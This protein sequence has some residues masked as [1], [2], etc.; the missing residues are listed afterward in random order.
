MTGTPNSKDQF[1]AINML[2]LKSSVSEVAPLVIRIIIELALDE[3]HCVASCRFAPDWN[4]RKRQ[5]DLGDQFCDNISLANLWHYRNEFGFS[6][7]QKRQQASYLPHCRCVHRS[8]KT[9]VL[10]SVEKKGISVEGMAPLY[11]MTGVQG[12]MIT[13]TCR[14]LE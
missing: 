3:S 9:L 6:Y 12:L 11:S 10:T 7:W 13:G 2:L 1:E 14:S 5:G 8:E 4:L